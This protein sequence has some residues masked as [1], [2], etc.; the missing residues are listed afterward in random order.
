MVG[1]LSSVGFIQATY[2]NDGFEILLNNTKENTHPHF[3]RFSRKIKIGNGSNLTSILIIA[4]IA[5]SSAALF[6]IIGFMAIR[7]FRSPKKSQTI[8][9]EKIADAVANNLDEV[10][11]QG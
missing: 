6:L 9:A 5:V 4:L 10:G 2:Q 7:Y 11:L 3:K 8:A 1:Q